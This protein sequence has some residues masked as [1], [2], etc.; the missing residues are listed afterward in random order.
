MIFSQNEGLEIYMIDVENPLYKDYDEN[1]CRCCMEVLPS[2]IVGEPLIK[3]DD[4]ERFDWNKQI[5]Y[6]KESGKIK[7]IDFDFMQP[8]QRLPGVAAVITLSKVPIY[9]LIIFPEGSSHGCD[10]VHTIIGDDFLVLRF[11]F[12]MGTKGRWSFGVDPRYDKRIEQYLEN[13]AS[14]N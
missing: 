5:I 6:L 7:L 14:H 9:P 12:R 8:G 13:R 10:R 2:N 11:G 3:D 1:N 4:I